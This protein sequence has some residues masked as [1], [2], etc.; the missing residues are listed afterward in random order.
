MRHTEAAT[1][2]ISITTTTTRMKIREALLRWG[3][4]AEAAKAEM[5][6]TEP[7]GDR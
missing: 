6:A 4:V 5:P 2:E 7:P 1:T 3:L